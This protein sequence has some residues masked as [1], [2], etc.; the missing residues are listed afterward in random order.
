MWFRSQINFKVR[1]FLRIALFPRFEEQNRIRKRKRI[2]ENDRRKI[3]ENAAS[4]IFCFSAMQWMTVCHCLLRNQRARNFNFLQEF[5][6]KHWIKGNWGYIEC[7]SISLLHC[8]H[9]N[10]EL[11][12]LQKVLLCNLFRIITDRIYFSQSL[13]FQEHWLLHWGRTE[14]MV[15]SLC[16]FFINTWPTMNY[17]EYLLRW[18]WLKK[19][20]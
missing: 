6:D 17:P 16:D 13:A 2:I 10:F 20:L 15:S 4:P 7:I 12:W 14:A 3:I 1:L 5:L 9:S 19:M 11:L 18:F 8:L